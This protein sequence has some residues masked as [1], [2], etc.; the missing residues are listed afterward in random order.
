MKVKDLMKIDVG[1]CS[2]EDNLK[3]A[4]EVMRYRIAALCR[5]LMR[6]IELSEC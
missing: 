5:L 6:S 2:T 3:K 4:A 1:F